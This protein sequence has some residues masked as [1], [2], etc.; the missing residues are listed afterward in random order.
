MPVLR[1]ASPSE[2]LNTEYG[3]DETTASD[4]ELS[5]EGF[6]LKVESQLRIHDK[7][8]VELLADTRPLIMPKPKK[9]GAG[10]ET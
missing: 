7:R 9:D 8:D 6:A 10:D 2:S 3:P 1:S 5:P 4:T